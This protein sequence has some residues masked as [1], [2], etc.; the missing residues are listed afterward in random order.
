MR[1]ERE[2]GGERGR[3]RRS[4]EGEREEKR[5]LC[6]R[7]VKVSGDVNGVC[8]MVGLCVCLCVHF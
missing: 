5:E 3:S 2:G 4:E 8:A 1:G 7:G 6:L